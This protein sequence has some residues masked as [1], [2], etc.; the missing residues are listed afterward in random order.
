MVVST[1]HVFYDLISRRIVRRLNMPDV[2]SEIIE[3][4]ANEI[5]LRLDRV[6][7]IELPK[8][9]FAARPAS[10]GSYSESIILV[11]KT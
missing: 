1:E 9:D 2:L 10:R 8:M 5:P 3:E 11:E 7:Q 6:V 4:P